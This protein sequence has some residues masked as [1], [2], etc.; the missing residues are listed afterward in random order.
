MF[1]CVLYIQPTRPSRFCHLNNLS[2]MYQPAV[3]LCTTYIHSMHWQ[4]SKMH[5]K[6]DSNFTSITPTPPR[7][8]ATF[9][10]KRR[11]ISETSLA[12]RVRRFDM[13]PPIFPS[14]LKHLSPLSKESVSFNSWYC[15]S[16][17]LEIR[18]CLYNVFIVDYFY[19]SLFSAH[20]GK[21]RIQE[22]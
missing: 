2:S 18:D 13:E 20:V 9:E 6:S 5:H 22:S 17:S 11:S 21:Y 7:C 1:Y 8:Y 10:V 15:V 19:V 3:R 12:P 4:S 14:S 16:H